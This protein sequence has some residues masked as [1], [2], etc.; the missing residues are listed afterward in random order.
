MIK[1]SINNH[2]S[3]ITNR[4][5]NGNAHRTN[6]SINGKF[7][8]GEINDPCFLN[9]IEHNRETHRIYMYTNTYQCQLMNSFIEFKTV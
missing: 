7:Y 3:A 5:M 8:S 6:R 2:H 4:S 1:I 9:H